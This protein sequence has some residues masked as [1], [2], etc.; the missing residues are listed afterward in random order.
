MK[1]LEIAGE[2]DPSTVKHHHFRTPEQPQNLAQLENDVLS[3]TRFSIFR[4]ARDVALVVAGRRRGLRASTS[5]SRPNFSAR[6][7]AGE[8]AR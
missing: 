5:C 8:A 7:L 1:P 6:Q 3:G 4:L 2:F